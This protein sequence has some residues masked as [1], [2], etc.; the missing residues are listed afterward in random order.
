MVD[1]NIREFGAQ[2]DGLADDSAAIQAAIDAC[3]AGGVVLIPEGVFACAEI[4]MKPHITLQGT[5]TWGY[6]D[7]RETGACMIPARDGAACLID[8]TDAV[9]C[10]L[11]GLSLCGQGR[12]EGMHGVQI[13]KSDGYGREEDAIRVEKCRISEFSGDA[14][15]LSHVWC[16][17]VRDNMLSSS[18]HGL[19][20]DGWDLFIY[21][22]WLTANR[23]CG[24]FGEF[25]CN[26]AIICQGNRVEWNG[27]E[28]ILSNGGVTWVLNGNHFDRNGRE[29][30]RFYHAKHINIVGNVFARDGWKVPEDEYS[31]GLTIEKSCGVSIQSNV[32]PLARGRRGR[33]SA[34]FP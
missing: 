9:G 8:I 31:A 13:V 10:T 20:I 4:R 34:A 28:G 14:L 3:P 16:A 25:Y 24:A 21:D 23:E 17:T 27:R 15:H 2:G 30:A 12:G 5:L 32:F 11:T 1:I 33:K 7:N 26:T 6:R 19:Y 29:G 22:N 18:R